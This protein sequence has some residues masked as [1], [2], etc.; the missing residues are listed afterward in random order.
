MNNC[1]VN[2]SMSTSSNVNI[3]KMSKEKKILLKYCGGLGSISH[4]LLQQKMVELMFKIVI[5]MFPMVFVLRIQHQ[6]IKGLSQTFC[7]SVM[8]PHPRELMMSTSFISSFKN[9]C[10]VKVFSTLTTAYAN[11]NEESFSSI[12]IVSNN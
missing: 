4:C 12:P 6:V 5:K 3:Y 8:K 1:N 2:K 11:G 7:L 9:Q 10:H